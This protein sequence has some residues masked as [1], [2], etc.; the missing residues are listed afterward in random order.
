MINIT[1]VCC[2]NNLQQFKEFENSLKSQTEEYKL[3]LIDNTN[4]RF[5]SCSEAFNSVLG[6]IETKYVI[7][8]HQ[9]II[10]DSRDMLKNFVK[11][12]DKIGEY[13]ILGV[14]GASNKKAHVMTNIRCTQTNTIAGQN[15]VN[16]IEECDTLDECFF[17]GSLKNFVENPFD[18]KV[19]NNWHLYA[20][21]RCL[22]AIS[23]GYKVYVCDV[24]LIH[25]SKGKIN[26]E[27][28]VGFFRLSKKYDKTIS[29]ISTTC[30]SAGTS[31][32]SRIW[33]YIKREISI[34]LGRY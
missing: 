10:L 8:S 30:A 34:S 2:C 17:A 1:I 6:Q 28:N 3:V 11:Y 24:P 33:S 22:N 18:E 32:K 25:N 27:Y 20:V 15:R 9:D 12:L 5:K 7:F 16:G 4:S 23:N 14:A 31:W 26:H 21:D 19:C 29:Y 13:D